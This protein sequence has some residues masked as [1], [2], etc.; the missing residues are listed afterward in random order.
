MNRAT[1]LIDNAVTGAGR[2]LLIAGEP[3]VGKTR[4]SQENNRIARNRGLL[5]TS[6]GSCYEATESIP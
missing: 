6:D 4:L 5:I 3:G 1:E 2:T